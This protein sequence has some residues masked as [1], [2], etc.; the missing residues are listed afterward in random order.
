MAMANWNRTATGST[1]IAPAVQQGAGGQV[2]LT[3]NPHG[4]PFQF[5]RGHVQIGVQALGSV[6]VPLT[7]A[8]GAP[9]AGLR[10]DWC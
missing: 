10:R 7:G 3:P 9:V 2:L 4:G 5:L 1:A 8:G 6:T